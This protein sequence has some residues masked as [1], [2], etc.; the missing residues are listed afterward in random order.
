M[1]VNPVTNKVYVTNYN[2]NSV[3]V[4]DGVTD[5]FPTNVTVG[6]YP[7]AVAVNPVTNKVY[8]VN[9][10]TSGTVSVIYGDNTVSLPVTVGG[11]PKAVA[12][13][14]VT[15]RSTLSTIITGSGTVS[16]IDGTSDSVTTTVTAGSNS[17]AVTVNPVSNKVF[18]ANESSNNVDRDRRRNLTVCGNHARRAKSRRCC[19]EHAHQCGLCRQ[20]RSC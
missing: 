12:I 7:R 5:V 14:P 1:A 17:R 18:V 11:Y 9:D 4:I 15:N 16:V 19:R 10:D 8:V 3:T 2:D 13:N 6:N 20:Q